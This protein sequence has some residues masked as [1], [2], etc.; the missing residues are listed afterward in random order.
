MKYIFAIPVLFALAETPIPIVQDLSQIG[1]LAVLAWFC[2]AQHNEMQEIRRGHAAI[3]NMLCER[4]DAWERIRHVD[5]EKLD[6]TLRM[7]TTRLNREK[8]Q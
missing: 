3:V 1:A 4:W 5:A 7:M 8:E 6:E 2:Y